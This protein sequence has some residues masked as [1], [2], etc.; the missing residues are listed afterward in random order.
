[1]NWD[2]VVQKVTPYLVKIETPINSGTG[3]LLSYNEDQFCAKRIYRV[4]IT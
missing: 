2:D 1:M 4:I 3:F